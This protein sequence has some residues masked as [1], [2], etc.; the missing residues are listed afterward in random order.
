MSSSNRKQAEYKIAVVGGGGV[1]KSSL[2]IQFV[3]HYYQAQYDP[4]I[5]D[6]YQKQIKVDDK[7][8]QLEITD[9]AGQD[10]FIALR[11]TYMRRNDGFVLVFDVTMKQSLEELINFVEG[12]KRVKEDNMLYTSVPFVIVA[13]KCDLADQRIIT[14]KEALQYI[15]EELQLPSDT[16]YFETKSVKYLT[17][18]KYFEGFPSY[19]YFE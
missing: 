18:F 14:K 15:V 5:E 1:G 6:S 16:P 4:T 2:T 10:E 8:V 13:N 11:D 7:V 17:P 3:Q 9:T 19:L 12:I